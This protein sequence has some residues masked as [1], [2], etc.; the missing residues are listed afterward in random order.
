M[1][2]QWTFSSGAQSAIMSRMNELVPVSDESQSSKFILADKLMDRLAKAIDDTDEKEAAARVA[3]LR[4]KHPDESLEK[5]SDRLIFAKMRETAVVGATVP[6]LIIHSATDEFTPA[7]HSEAIFANANPEIT[8]LVINE[9]GAAHARDILVDYA[10]YEALVD[11][12]ISEELTVFGQ[13][14]GR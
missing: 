2:R 10:A 1:N 13:G 4:A 5:L 6:T 8:T 9:W 7:A 14:D 11:Q 12:F 3:K